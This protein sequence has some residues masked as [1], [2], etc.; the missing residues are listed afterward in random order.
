MSQ[1]LDASSKVKKPEEKLASYSYPHR[2]C[3]YEV[4]VL[5]MVD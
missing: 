1:Q 5:Y 2:E 4:S 3:G